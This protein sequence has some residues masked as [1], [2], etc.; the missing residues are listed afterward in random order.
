MSK[1][2]VFYHN[3][4]DGHCAGAIYKQFIMDKD[5]LM[6]DT[7]LEMHE[8]NYGYTYDWMSVLISGADLIVFVD[9][10]PTQKDMEDLLNKN[11]PLEIYDH[12]K[13][14]EWVKTV[15]DITVHHLSDQSGCQIVWDLCYPTKPMPPAVWMVGQWDLWKHDD[16]RV[17]PFVTGLRMLI[18]DPSTEDGYEF[19][20]ACFDTADCLPADADPEEKA[21]RMKWDVVMQVI[22]MGQVAQMYRA[23][24]AEEREKQ[25]HD[26]IIGGKK[27]LMLNT[28]LQDA[29]D[30]PTNKVTDEYFGYGWYWWDGTRW[31]VSVRS[32][33]DN[34]LTSV[35]FHGHKNAA[36]TSISE[37][38]M[39]STMEITLESN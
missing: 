35:G 33:G 14:S 12:H 29:Y 32:L 16:P 18:T 24:I 2:V 27:F 26:F 22:N 1:I 9:F 36:G 28:K 3:D 20:K 11:I 13:S 6:K 34:D 8:I 17:V 37:L 19:W 30:F 10:C 21:K 25:L 23:G 31:I 15:P 4:A 39:K 5:P 38:T 7:V